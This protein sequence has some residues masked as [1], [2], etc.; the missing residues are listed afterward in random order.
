MADF[1]RFLVRLGWPINT[2]ILAAFLV[3]AWFVIRLFPR[4]RP[5]TGQLLVL[6]GIWWVGTVFFVITF[7][8][9]SPRFGVGITEAGTIPRVWYFALI[10]VTILALIP[11]F[12]GKEDPDPKWGNIRLVGTILAALII[13]ISLFSFIG[14]YI[15]S[16]LFIIVS[17]WVLGSRSKVELA[18][19]PVGW[20]V[21]SYFIF[22]RLLNVRLPIGSLFSGFF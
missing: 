14:Y 6:L 10:P 21:F 18:A 22:A 7:S 17:M 15:S 12:R 16:A 8:I 13:S 19:V 9:P 11:I 1:G 20:V 4:L 5:Y 2:A 3:I